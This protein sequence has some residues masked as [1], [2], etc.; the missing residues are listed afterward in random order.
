VSSP[1]CFYFGC[2]NRPGHYLHAPGGHVSWQEQ[3]TLFGNGFHL[4]GTLAPRKNSAGQVFWVA[5]AKDDDNNR[6]RFRYAGSECP[7]GQFLCHVLDNGFTA[8]QWWDRCQGDTRGACNSTILL[9][10]EHTA[11]EMIAALEEHFPHVLA[12]LKRGGVELVQVTPNATGA[13]P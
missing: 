10:G 13:V 2:W 5:L 4:D 6:E 1:R 3:V 8:I 9:E 11:E 7:Q 12:N